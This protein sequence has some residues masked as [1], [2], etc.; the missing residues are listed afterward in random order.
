MIKMNDFIDINRIKDVF[1][2]NKITK[3]QIQIFKILILFIVLAIGNKTLKIFEILL[4]IT[5]PLGF[6]YLLVQNNK[7]P[8]EKKLIFKLISIVYS[9]LLY[10]YFFKITEII[11]LLIAVSILIVTYLL[12]KEKIDKV[13]AKKYL[14]TPI[15]F[16]LMINILIIKGV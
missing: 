4:Y 7:I 3:H 6:I 15:I 11:L 1:N 2:I 10:T 12:K 8:K 13:N 14:I 9:L 5:L 16:L